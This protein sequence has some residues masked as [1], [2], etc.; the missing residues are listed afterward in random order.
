MPKPA[1]ARD[2]SA[3]REMSQRLLEERTGKTLAAW[4]RRV[5]RD[6]PASEAALYAWLE[7]EG[8]TGYAAQ[9][10][11]WERL[12]YPGFMTASADELIEGQLADKPALRPVYERVVEAALACGE[13]VVQ[14]RKT[15]VSLRT[16]KRTFARIRATT[17]TRL[18]VALRLDRAPRGRL[19]PSRIHE[20]MPV[21]IELAAL[22]DFDAEARRLLALAYAQNA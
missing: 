19:K 1:A 17:K 16:P 14:A 21:Q 2:W 20:E 15:Y 7:A 8:V 11:V 12:G 13:V 3:M 9:L 18:D 10:L 6:A 5:K 4:N 22:G